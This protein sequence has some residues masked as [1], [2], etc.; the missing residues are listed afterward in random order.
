MTEQ[1]DAPDATEPVAAEAR[2]LRLLPRNGKKGGW[3]DVRNAFEGVAEVSIQDEI[4]GYGLSAKDF[5]DEV[6]ALGPVKALNVHINSPGGSVFAGLAI[7]NYLKRMDAEVTVYIDGLAASIASVIAMAGRVVVPANACLMIHD[8]SGVAM[9]TAEDMLAMATALEKIKSSLVTV[10]TEKTGKSAEDIAAMMAAETWMTAAEAV[11]MGFADELVEPVRM[12]ASF[13]VSRFENA[14]DFLAQAAEPEPEAEPEPAVVEPE[15]EVVEEVAEPVDERDYHAEAVEIAALCA[16]ASAS[17][18]EFISAKAV[19][20]DV[21]AKL[22][23]ISKIRELCARAKAPDMLAKLQGGSIEDAR[24]A[25]FDH[26]INSQSPE[27]AAVTPADQAMP[28]PAIDTAAVY[29]RRNQRNT[30]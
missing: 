27:I 20:A 10:Y 5:I 23:T 18:A 14:P 1:H 4:G 15:P 17:A 24:A 22:D 19:P 7:Y 6:K 9:G 2:A 26:L 8:P 16:E 21:N 30:K 28:K 13:D 3:Y 29:A 11:E 12:A 25:L